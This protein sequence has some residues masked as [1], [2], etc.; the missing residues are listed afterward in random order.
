MSQIIL[1]P[2]TLA[3]GLVLG[4]VIAKMTANRNR[5]KILD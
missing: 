2:L 3:M 4:Y 1:I 5:G